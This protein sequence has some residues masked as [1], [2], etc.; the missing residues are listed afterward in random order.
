MGGLDES[1][2]DF[3]VQGLR[4]DVIDVVSCFISSITHISGNWE[5]GPT[6]PQGVL[7]DASDR[8]LVCMSV[9]D[10]EVIVGSTDHA[11]YAFDANSG[12]YCA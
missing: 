9:L 12:T 6:C 5:R 2:I 7:C 3:C 10:D 11:L 1:E 8:N 4:G